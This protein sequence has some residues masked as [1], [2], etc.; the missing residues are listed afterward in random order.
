MDQ[1][2]SS[3]TKSRMT[4]L[5]G[6]YGYW[7]VLT[8]L[9]IVSAVAGIIFAIS[10]NVKFA[11]ICLMFSGVCDMFDGPVARLAK[12]T[13][14]EKH[15]GIQIDSLAD[16]IAFGLLPAVLGYTVCIN[17]MAEI[18]GSFALVITAAIMSI[19]ILAALI[20]LAYF[21]VIEAELQSRS[22]N[23][24]YYEG[25]PVTSVAL[26]IPIVYSICSIFEF[27]L[28]QVYF[29]LLIVVSAAFL[30]RI[31]IPKLRIRYLIG[32]CLLGMPLIVYIF[33]S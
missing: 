7:V 27:P 20:R 21:N 16:V 33:I 1:L 12:R 29:P 11:V 30:L 10:G 14:R 28:S 31:K 2:S 9:G 15:F 5:L 8:Y 22:E 18:F 3:E 13:D 23:R 4:P 17:Y 6:F 25:L 32:F 19:Y 24:K 26:L